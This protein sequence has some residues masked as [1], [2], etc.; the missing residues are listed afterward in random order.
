LRKAVKDLPRDKTFVLLYQTLQG[1]LETRLRI[2]RR[3]QRH[4]ICCLAFEYRARR[5]LREA[6]EER[7]HVSQKQ[8]AE[9]NKWPILEP[10]EN[11][12]EEDEDITAEESS[13]FTED[14]YGYYSGSFRMLFNSCFVSFFYV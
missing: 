13:D 4:T 9:L 14:D 5:I 1:V 3:F 10:G 6:C 2:A 11:S 12:C 8:L 7:F